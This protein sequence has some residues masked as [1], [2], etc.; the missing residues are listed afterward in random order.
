MIKHPQNS[1]VVYARM[2]L[3]LLSKEI[4][5]PGHFSSQTMASSQ[6]KP[7]KRKSAAADSLVHVSVGDSSRGSGPAFGKSPSRIVKSIC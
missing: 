5:S 3:L 6:K 4:I 1:K 2:K 7:Q